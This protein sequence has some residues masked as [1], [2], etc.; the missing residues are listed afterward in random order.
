[1]MKVA[2]CL[3]GVVAVG[4]SLGVMRADAGESKLVYPGRT[5]ETKQPSEAGLDE[6]KLKEMSDYAGGFGCVVRGGYMVYTW[7]DP[8]RRMDVASAVKPVYTHFLLKAVESGKIKGFDE[9]VG[10]FEPRLKSLNEGLGHK[11]RE[12]TW[13][14]L[15]NQISCYGVAERP[16]QAFDYSDWNMA[17]LFDTLFLK[18]YGTSWDK[19]DADVL[20]PGLTDLLECEDKPTF[21][22][23]GTDNR[24]G[25]LGISPRD[26]AR[27]G[28][29]YLRKGKWQ[30]KQLISA[31]L[32]KLAVGSPLPTSIPR[33]EGAKAEMIEG[34][35][36]IGGGNNQ[37]DHNGN[38]SFAWWVN[39]V[40]RDGTRN[41]PDVGSDVYGCFGHGDI[42]AMVVMPSLDLI[43][44]WNDT[45]IEGS[46]KVNHAL[47]LVKDSVMQSESA[48][49]IV[50]DPENRQ[51]LKRK[52][53]GPFFMC[54]PG[55]PEDFLYRGKL[56][57]DGTRDGDQESLIEKVKG[58]GANCIYL[59]AVRSHGGD[60]D[61]T[62]NP[63]VGHDQSKGVNPKV[64]DH[65]EQW[66]AEM[67]RNGI[68][69]FFFFYDDSACVWKTGDNVGDQ[70]RTFIRIIVDRFEHHKNLIWCVAEEYQ[71]A[72]SAKRVSNIAA[73]IRAADDYDHPIAVH[74]LN[75]LDF[76]EFADDENIDQFAIQYNEASADVLHEGVVRAWRDANG[77]Y[78]LNMSEAK[79][80]STGKS[81]RDKCW[82]CAMGGAYVM[83][84]D[85]DIASTPKSD[86]EDCGRLVR[87]FESTNFNE[88]E[89]HDE[90]AFAGTKYV[91]A[92]PGDSYIAYAADLAG[93]I[94]LKDLEPGAYD[95]Q[96][97]DCATGKEVV[98]KAVKVAAGNQGWATPEGIG[99]EL[100]VYIKRIK[101]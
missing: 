61:K 43:V 79:G 89:P 49:G 7:G 71:E 81:M 2:R 80:F 47:K 82:A 9:P 35:R 87:F 3:L 31:E 48:G 54:G 91:L 73:E 44:S 75:G 65:W 13:R 74:K 22:A 46:E 92:N 72:F 8:G 57:P 37:C 36:S 60:G 55:D 42:R 30:D 68:V 98:Q 23:F 83:I 59:M 84:L 94:G 52:N 6:Q 5:W 19:V 96:W 53:G 58:T 101:Q 45:R 95:L 16:G 63:F 100:A 4:I 78:N 99:T 12:I 85:M 64:L 20:G 62:H 10:E 50:A 40:G 28:L 66:F 41:W 27:F 97:F 69:V 51:W 77:R 88:M 32:A 17:L 29:L 34:Q 21:M 15:C 67:D 93:E 11:D 26:F 70:E 14:H 25:R 38:Y 33:T 24:P 76:D 56:K 18:V 1:M 86:L 90:L 39:G